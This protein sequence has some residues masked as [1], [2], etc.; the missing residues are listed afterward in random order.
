MDVIIPDCTEGSRDSCNKLRTVPD[1]ERSIDVYFYLAK[2]YLVLTL[3]ESKVLFGSME[4][5]SNALG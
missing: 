3:S 5:C 4:A 2:A 1:K